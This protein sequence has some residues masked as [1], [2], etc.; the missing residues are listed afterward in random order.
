M[1]A[2]IRAFLLVA[3]VLIAKV[4]DS[5]ATG[6]IRMDQMFGNISW[7]ISVDDEMVFV[8]LEQLVA[9]QLQSVDYL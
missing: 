1:D 2:L 8:L 3:T 7:K 5:E 4:Q 9:I 6:A